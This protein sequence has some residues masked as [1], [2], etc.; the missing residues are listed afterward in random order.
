M[1]ATSHLS[2]HDRKLLKAI[3]D[4]GM[5]WDFQ[6]CKLAWYAQQGYGLDSESQKEEVGH[7]EDRLGGSPVGDD[8]DDGPRVLEQLLNLISQ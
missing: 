4:L 5:W 1:H 2:C 3:E 8:G 6:G 7:E